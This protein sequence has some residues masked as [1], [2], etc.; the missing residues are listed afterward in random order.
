M[1][2]PRSRAKALI[3]AVTLA[4]VALPVASASALE[5]SQITTPSGPDFVQLEKESKIAIAGTSSASAVDIRCYY[6]SGLGDYSTLETNVPVTGGA[7]SVEASTD[8]LTSRV[9]QLRAVPHGYKESPLPPG[10]TEAFEGP[11]ILASSFVPSL[12]SN[13]FAAS[14]SLAGDFEFESASGYAL[15]SNLYSPSAHESERDF[16]GEADLSAYAPVETR[17]TIQV[18][19]VDSYLPGAIGEVEKGLRSEAETDK[20]TYVPPTG[21]PALVVRHEFDPGGAVGAIEIEEEDPIVKCSPGAATFKPTIASCTSFVSTGVKLDRKWLTS[22]E[23]HVAS[24]ADTW[25]STDGAAHAVNA[26]YFTEMSSVP[27]GGAYE[28]AGETGFGAIAEGEAKTLPAGAGM[29]LYKTSATV[30]EV[31]NGEDPQAAIVYD[32]APNEP[33]AVTAGSAGHTYSNFEDPYQRAIP[34]GGST[35]LRMTFVQ[36]FG[37]AEVR[38]LAA[39]AISSYSP[40]V[41]IASPANGSTVTTPSVTVSGTASDS[42][43]LSSLTVNGAAV[44]VSSSGTWSTSVALKA[45]ANTIA[46]TATDQ[47]GL[48]SIATATVTYVAPSPKPVPATASQV[49]GASGA[50]GQATVTLACHG[51]AGTS[52]K[53]H[54]SLTTV[55]RLRHGRLVAVVAVK[56]HSKQVT[57]ASLTVVIPAGQQIKVSLKLN[58]TGRKLLARFG[59]LPAHLT[60]ILEGEGAR[61]TIVAQ[62]LTIKPKPKQ[63]KH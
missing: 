7:F 54:V 47:A 14:T 26:R 35:T 59:K 42:G 34:A 19:G 44:A 58:A 16:Y 6:G 5:S 37:L 20:Q 36:A 30:S 25:V 21:A 40:T 9:C 48:T 12:A 53:I 63:H 46:A 33:L 28:F 41:A 8:Y 39:A 13:Y 1:R 49:G 29:I 51:A 31:G 27:A 61:H 24:M 57:V 43:A 52:C 22:D 2:S 62:N 10:E 45:G 23:D 17:S 50:K 56:T 38:T 11:L 60:A 4:L 15:E 3:V 55:E 32:S 18:D